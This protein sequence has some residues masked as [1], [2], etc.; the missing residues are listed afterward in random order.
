M[1]LRHQ[2][3]L[4]LAL[5]QALRP[6][7]GCEVSAFGLWPRQH[8]PWRA[9]WPW[10]C[11]SDWRADWPEPPLVMNRIIRQIDIEVPTARVIDAHHADDG[12]RTGRSCG[13][14]IAT[15]RQAQDNLKTQMQARTEKLQQALIKIAQRDEFT[16]TTLDLDRDGVIVVFNRSWQRFALANEIE[17][18]KRGAHT[19]VGV[20]YL[21]IYQRTLHRRVTKCH[22]TSNAG[23]SCGQNAPGTRV[24]G[25]AMY[26]TT[27]FLSASRLRKNCGSIWKSAHRAR[28][29]PVH[30]LAIRIK[31]AV[32]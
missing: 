1:S 20:D 8:S 9:R 5:P 19:D 2:P 24:R 6:V 4:T 17:P 32:F 15:P 29:L 31:K 7:H 13:H 21:E 26:G 18:G 16:R 10:S 23:S 14:M 28:Q 12:R 27:V 30:G 25:I 3:V 11:R 22:R